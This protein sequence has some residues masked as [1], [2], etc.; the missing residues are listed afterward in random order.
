MVLTAACSAANSAAIDV[1][2]RRVMVVTNVCSGSGRVVVVGPL[3]QTIGGPFTK[4]PRYFAGVCMWGD[5]TAR[6]VGV[7]CVSRQSE[8][9][10]QPS[11]MYVCMYYPLSLYVCMNDVYMHGYFNMYNVNKI[12][13]CMYEYFNMYVCMCVRMYVCMYVCI[14]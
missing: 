7:A 2:D 10:T 14:T 9:R 13:A 4:A 5:A 6:D 1:S 8:I 12:F 11:M 3:R